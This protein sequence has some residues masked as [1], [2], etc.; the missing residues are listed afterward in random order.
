MKETKA[1]REIVTTNNTSPEVPSDNQESPNWS[2][3]TKLVFGLVLVG[4]AI[5]L[6]VQFQ[7]FLGPIISAFILSYLIH[8]IARFIQEKTKLPW[9][10]SVT[11]I[12]I[13]LVLAILG[14]L[15]WGGIALVEQ[16]Q[17][18]IQFIENNIDKFPDL[19]AQLTEQTYRIGPFSFSLSGLNWDLACPDLAG[20]LFPF[21]RI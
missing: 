8:P 18:L 7:T 16:V 4:V 1:E 17:N 11:L 19:V 5:W 13:I 14:L 2:W 15:T 10:V 6:L 9:R 21:S 12:Y 3:T 20:F